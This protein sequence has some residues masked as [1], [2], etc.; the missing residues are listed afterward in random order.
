MV[1]P[2]KSLEDFKIE[3]SQDHELLRSAIRDFS[4]NVLAK[5]VEKGEKELD[6]PI[7]IKAKRKS[8]SIRKH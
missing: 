7:K 5:Y 8:W 1:F 3:I 6:I 4:E 2:F